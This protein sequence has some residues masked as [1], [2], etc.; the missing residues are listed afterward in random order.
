M[1]LGMRLAMRARVLEQGPRAYVILSI[2]IERMG[3]GRP[4]IWKITFLLS[5]V[6][7]V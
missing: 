6:M 1:M 5:C 4:E 2:V 7:T 3:H